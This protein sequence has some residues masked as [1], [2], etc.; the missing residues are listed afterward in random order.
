LVAL[1]FV[2]PE[3][4]P[5]DC[6]QPQKFYGF[7]KIPTFPVYNRITCFY[8]SADILPAISTLQNLILIAFGERNPA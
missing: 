8:G 1:L 4:P 3:L 5:Q 7:S 2:A 6:D